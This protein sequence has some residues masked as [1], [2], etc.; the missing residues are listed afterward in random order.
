MAL[1]GGVWVT[2]NKKLPGAYINFV[3]ADRASAMLADRGVCAVPMSLSWGKEGEV[4]LVENTEFIRDSKSIFGYEYTHEKL[5]GIREVF[6]NAQK[7]Y[8]YRLNAGVKATC[9]YATAKFSGVRGN[10]LKIAII[11]NVDVSGM[12]DVKTLL[13]TEVVDVQTVAA[14]SE[15]VSNDF[16]DFNT[17]ATLQITASTPLVG[18]TDGETV[19]ASNWQTA[20]AKLESVAFNVLGI[21]TTYDEIKA[22]AVAYTKRLRDEQGVKFQTVVHQY[23]EANDKGVISVENTLPD[24][25]ADLVYWVAGAQAGCTVNKSCTNKIYDG[26]L[27]INVDYTQTQLEQ[28]I[29]KGKF[30]FHKVGEDIRVLT[31]INTKTTV[32]VEEG[33]DFKSN[34]TVRVLDQIGNDIAALFNTRYLGIIP[35]DEQGRISF[36]NDV[37]RHHEELQNIRAIEEFSSEDVAVSQGA[38]KKDVVVDSHVKPTNA[39]ERLYMT[40]V[41]G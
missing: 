22:L 27:T 9:D 15:L 8:V 40:T 18:G 2:Q 37:V 41:V 34:Q 38:T 3:S 7:L 20:L 28:C 19:T 11:A 31:D 32:S 16:V 33:E 14:A 12:F 23:E 10:D 13:G 36:W 29:D 4:F 25:S 30:V 21:V 35:N 24:L 17:E 5:K 6:K 26:E 1:G 39:M